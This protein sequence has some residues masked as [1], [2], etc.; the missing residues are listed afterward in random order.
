[1][2]KVNSSYTLVMGYVAPGKIFENM[3]QLMNILHMYFSV[4][5]EIYLNTINGYFYIHVETMMS[6]LHITL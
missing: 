6:A 4:Y 5:F 3:L 1:M 2:Q